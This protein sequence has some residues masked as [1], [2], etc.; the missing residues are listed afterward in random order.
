MY[1]ATKGIPERNLT[2]RRGVGVWRDTTPVCV[3][4]LVKKSI[5]KSLRVP[6]RKQHR[7]S[8]TYDPSV[9]L[10]RPYQRGSKIQSNNFPA[11]MSVIYER[12]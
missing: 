4:S 1:E 11:E 2:I 10:N 12:Q 3:C 6:E 8:V 9:Q 7:K 5:R